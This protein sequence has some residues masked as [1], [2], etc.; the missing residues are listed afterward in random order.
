[1]TAITAAPRAWA[2]G[3]PRLSAPAL[4]KAPVYQ[5]SDMFPKELVTLAGQSYT[6]SDLV[7]ACA[8]VVLKMK[9]AAN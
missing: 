5:R 4:E 3:W 1:M 8:A 7:A 2:G 6:N 9:A